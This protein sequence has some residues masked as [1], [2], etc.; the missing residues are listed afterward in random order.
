MYETPKKCLVSISIVDKMTC[1][2]CEI[3]MDYDELCIF[4][5][6]RPREKGGGWWAR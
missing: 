4:T 3:P 6:Q 2:P 1:L 5:I